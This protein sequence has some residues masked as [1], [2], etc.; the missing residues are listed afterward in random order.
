[1]PLANNYKTVL[2]VTYGSGDDYRNWDVTKMLNT[3]IYVGIQIILSWMNRCQ[4][5]FIF[6]YLTAN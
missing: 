3:L 6:T 2:V 5:L 4:T 1:M